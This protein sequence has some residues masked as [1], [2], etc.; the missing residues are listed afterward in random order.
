MKSLANVLIPLIDQNKF[1]CAYTFKKIT[2][3]NISW[4]LNKETASV[5]F[6]F[7]HIAEIQLLLGQFLGEATEVSN[8][9]MGFQDTGQGNNLEKSKELLQD[10]YKMLLELAEKHPEYWWMETIETPFFGTVSRLAM[11]GHILNHNAHHSGQ[12][13]LTLARHTVE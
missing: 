11:M 2:T 3:E 8:T 4:R 9:T 13:S 12:I 7:R 6:I 5:G 10:G 1:T